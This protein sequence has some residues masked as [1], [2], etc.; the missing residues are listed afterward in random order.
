L[1]KK[2]LQ[3]RKIYSARFFEQ[4]R[5][6]SIASARMAVPK[7]LEIYPAR[8]VVDVGCSIGAWLKV[9][10]DH[11]VRRIA[12]LDG[13]YVDRSQL[14]IDPACFVGC[15]LD[16]PLDIAG[17]LRQFK[18]SER[19]D[20][21]I[22]LEVGEHLPVARATSLVADMCSLS[23]TV[24]FGAAIPFQGWQS[25]HINEQWQ[26]FWVE[27][28]AENGYDA[29][30]ALRPAIWSSPDIAYFYKQ[31]SLSYLKRHT[32]VH[33]AFM[34]RYLRPTAAMFDVVHPEHYRAGVGRC[35]NGLAVQRLINHFR[36]SGGVR[37]STVLETPLRGDDHWSSDRPSGPETRSMPSVK[38]GTATGPSCE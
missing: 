12:G 36:L 5:D 38:S 22:S 33:A 31:N 2:I 16:E 9:F 10:A 25:A 15:N 21:A 7:I 24:L 13:D 4:I 18:K 17:I 26:S 37:R 3:P 27:K 34:A 14:M 8:S 32:D 28:F 1:F 11:G 19:F 29:F 30:D 6:M 23:D 20:L 35:K